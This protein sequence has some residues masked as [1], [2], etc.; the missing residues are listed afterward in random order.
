M[1]AFSRWRRSK[2][3]YS[4]FISTEEALNMKIGELQTY[5]DLDNINAAAKP[6]L[7][8]IILFVLF[9][10]FG[11]FYSLLIFPLLPF[12][13]VYSIYTE[14]KTEKSLLNSLI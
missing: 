9:A 5:L 13:I 11:L 8:D 7:V 10:L 6:S 3:L 2:N 4:Y 1:K 14:L 12:I